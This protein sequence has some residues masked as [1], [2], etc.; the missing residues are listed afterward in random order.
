MEAGVREYR[1]LTRRRYRFAFLRVDPYSP[2]WDWGF[3]ALAVLIAGVA[4]LV[5]A[6]LISLP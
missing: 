2:H 5:G 1:D 4:T 3:I 6:V